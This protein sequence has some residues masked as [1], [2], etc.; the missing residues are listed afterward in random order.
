[1]LFALVAVH[2]TTRTPD[3]SV[4]RGTTERHVVRVTIEPPRTGRIRATVDLTDRDG[5]PA[6]PREVVLEA[7]MP[8]MGHLSSELPTA[9]EKPGRFRATGELF[10]MVGVWELTVRIDGGELVTVSVTVIR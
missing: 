6:T 9:R 2:R 1:V 8:R 10:P 5:R 4:L 7:V 3:Q